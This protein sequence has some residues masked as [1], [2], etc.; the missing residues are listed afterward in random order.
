VN[1]AAT[2][3]LTDALV[4]GYAPTVRRQIREGVIDVPAGG[5]VPITVRRDEHPVAFR[6]CVCGIVAMLVL[7][8]VVSSI[9]LFGG[10]A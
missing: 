3:L 4:A 6:L 8:V 2:A 10:R 5:I 7:L 1:H 9:L